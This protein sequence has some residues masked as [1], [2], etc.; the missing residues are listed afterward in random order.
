M[1][2]LLVSQYF[3]PEVFRI[4]DLAEALRSRGHDLTVLTGQPNY[5]GGRF[6]SGHGLLRPWAECRDG[7]PV[8]RCPLI[9]RG[10]GGGVRLFLNYLSFALSACL[11]APFRCPGRYDVIFVYAPSPITVALPALLLRALGR[12]PV[13]LWVLDLWPESV[14]AAGGVRSRPVLAGLSR[15]VRFIYRHCD[16]VLV[17]SQAF[18][19][20]VE[21]L[22][23]KDHQ[24]RVFPSWAD[25]VFQQNPGPNT[26]AMPAGFRV[27]F[28]GNIGAAQDFPGILGAAERLRDQPDIHWVIAGGGRMEPWVRE[29]IK[30]RGLERQV[31]L[32]GSHP[33]EAMP[34]LYRDADCLLVTLRRE[35]IFALTIPAKIQSYLASGRP[36]VAMLDGVGAQV[37][38]SSGA[39]FAGPAQDSQTLAENVLRMFRLQVAER[40]AMGARGKAYCDRE[41]S[42][43]KLMT[44]LERWMQEV[45]SARATHNSQG[46]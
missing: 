28:A 37:V 33:V 17:Q 20:R 3:A 31:H 36:I 40:N 8:L 27:L 11:L 34:A 44:N 39:G 4:N 21:A 9:P 38:E 13:L 25:E 32:V 6:F 15:L 12:G 29:Q 45:A 14:E 30:T 41:F 10:R 42:R 2:I 43:D 16:R 19:P 46:K 26:V 23:V 22:G 24:L 1:R 5:P 7:V 18:V 35:A